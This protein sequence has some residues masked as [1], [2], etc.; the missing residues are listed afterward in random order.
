MILCNYFSTVVYAL[1]A[2]K[3]FHYRIPFEERTLRHHFGSAYDD[4]ASKTF[5]GI[6]FL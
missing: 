5:V 6:P 1:A 4:Y 3:F 2:W